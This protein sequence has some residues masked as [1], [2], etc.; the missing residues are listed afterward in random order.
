LLRLSR[1]RQACHLPPSGVADVRGKLL[2]VAV[3]VPWIEGSPL[4]ARHAMPTLDL[5]SHRDRSLLT[6]LLVEYARISSPE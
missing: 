2:D 3:L 1:K 5:A 6:Y 4:W